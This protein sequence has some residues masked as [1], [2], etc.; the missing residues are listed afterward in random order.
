MVRFEDETWG[1]NVA[2]EMELSVREQT[3]E[4]SGSGKRSEVG[5]EGSETFATEED[6]RLVGKMVKGKGP[7]GDAEG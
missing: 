7:F 4:D 3:G 6:P 5:T 1:E 2:S